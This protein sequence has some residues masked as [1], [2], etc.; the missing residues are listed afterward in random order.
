MK[1]IYFDNPHQPITIDNA[2]YEQIATWI[3]IGRVC[4][5][6]G[7]PYTDQ[8]PWVSL[9]TCLLCFL[10]REDAKG[11]TFAGVLSKDR[12]GTL[13]QFLDPKG[14]VSYTSTSSK[15]SERS[16]YETIKHWGFPV[17]DSFLLGE[18]TVELSPFRWYIHG[19]VKT[20]SVLVLE[21]LEY[22]SG[23]RRAFL[24]YKGGGCVF[25]TRR[26]GTMRSLWNQ[27]ME[28][29]KAQKGDGSSYYESEIY[30]IIADLASREYEQHQKE[31]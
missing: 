3:E 20:H 14:Y 19:D 24:S 11:L 29:L 17:M 25:F 10:K 9:N 27:A 22:S 26:K 8:N 21:N 28:R 1:T 4:G 6:C 13:Y 15:K 12:Y 2:T 18:T 7:K 31:K 30:E 16:E 5:T 23:T